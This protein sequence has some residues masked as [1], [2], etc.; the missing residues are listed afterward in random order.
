MKDGP[1]G[2]DCSFRIPETGNGRFNDTSQ[3][4]AVRVGRA[5]GITVRLIGSDMEYFFQ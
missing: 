2:H 1:D 5:L 3:E 4:I